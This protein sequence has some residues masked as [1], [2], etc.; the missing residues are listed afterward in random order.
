MTAP[1]HLK[2]S[3]GLDPAIHAFLVA[4]SVRTSS[5]GFHR[6]EVLRLRRRDKPGDDGRVC[7]NVGKDQIELVGKILITGGMLPPVINREFAQTIFPIGS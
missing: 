5:P 4:A 2:T 3:S 6:D 1:V 7:G